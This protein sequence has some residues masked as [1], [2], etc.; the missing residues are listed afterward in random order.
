MK[1]TG[2]FKAVIIV[3]ILLLVGVLAGGGYYLKKE[4]ERPDYFKNTSV[5]GYDMSGKTPEQALAQMASD[6]GNVHVTLMENNEPAITGA[7]ADFG[8]VVDQEKLSA[9][10][11]EAFDRQRGD[12]ISLI[13][14][15]SGGSNFNVTIPFKYF[16]DKLTA[17]VKAEN[18]PAERG[19]S[20]DA[21]IKYKKKRKEYIIKPE[22]NGTEF[23]DAA[24]QSYV[25]DR[26]AA[27]VSEDHPGEDL[28]IDFPTDLYFKPAVTQQDVTLNTTVNVYNQF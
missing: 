27:F 20:V 24:L 6:Y 5:N 7:L 16:D 15:L 17:L 14:G 21:K 25:N 28:T 18:L 4:S 3:L 8:Y 2:A 19:Q 26:I 10:L 1:T 12:V 13:K 22:V 23:D 11:K 9:N